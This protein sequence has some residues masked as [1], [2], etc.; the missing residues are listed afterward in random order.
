MLS[1]IAVNTIVA[2][3]RKRTC[4]GDPAVR[5]KIKHGGFKEPGSTRM[6]QSATAPCELASHP[7][8]NNANTATLTGVWSIVAVQL[9]NIRYLHYVLS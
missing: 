7:S 5:W 3:S 8:F 1:Q 2:R 6:R 9:I 4:T